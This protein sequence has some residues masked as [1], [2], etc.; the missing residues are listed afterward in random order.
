[1]CVCYLH[2]SSK[3]QRHKIGM[4]L[5]ASVAQTAC[6]LENK[7]SLM[8]RSYTRHLFKIKAL[9]LKL[10]MKNKIYTIL[11]ILVRPTILFRLLPTGLSLFIS[12]HSKLL[13]LLHAAFSFKVL[14]RGGPWFFTNIYGHT[15]KALHISLSLMHVYIPMSTGTVLQ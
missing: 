8:Y 10:E 4:F 2:L 3:A 6:E 15:I 11:Q 12:V 14:V 5:Q 1:M 9:Y 13:I 7:T